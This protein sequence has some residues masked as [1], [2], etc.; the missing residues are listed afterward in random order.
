MKNQLTIQRMNQGKPT[1]KPTKRMDL[2]AELPSN[3]S[4]KRVMYCNASTQGPE[5]ASNGTVQLRHINQKKRV[6]F[7]DKP[8]PVEI[9]INPPQATNTNSQ[10]MW[11]MPQSV[12]L[13]TSGL[14]CSS[15]TEILNRCGQVY[16]NTS[17]LSN[18]PLQSASN[19][20]FKSALVIFTSIYT[21][22]N[23][24]RSIAHSL[25]EEDTKTSTTKSA[26]SNAMDSYH[27]VNTLYDGMINCFSTQQ[28]PN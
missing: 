24:L 10:N 4:S 13:D 12:N 16:S 2:D 7:S 17:T 27:Q 3:Q 20:C 19:R 28:W 21:I 15:I 25:Q 14:R 18:A 1:H 6:S 9:E 5:G 22:G 8:E 23:R 26:F 11:H